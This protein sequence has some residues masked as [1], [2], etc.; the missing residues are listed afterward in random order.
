MEIVVGNP[1]NIDAILEAFPEAEGKAIFAYDGTIYNPS[2]F[3][4]NPW[5]I[6]H[7]EVHFK[8]QAE[9]FVG[10]MNE[11]KTG[12]EVWWEQYIA[13][14]K[15]RAEQELPAYREEYRYIKQH[16]GIEEARRMA[17]RFSMN[18]SG[19][20]YGECVEYEDALQYITGSTL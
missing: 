15:F 9:M 3:A 16:K 5:N 18:V 6:V 20:M 14:P 13:D 12:V 2:G 17:V 8:Q 7:E 19:P 11:G 1:P 4:L 10:L